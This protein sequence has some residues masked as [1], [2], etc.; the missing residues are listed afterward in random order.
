LKILIV[1]DHRK[2]NDI[3]TK[4]ARGEG[5]HVVQAYD[6]GEA[7]EEL[8]KQAFNIVITD[9]MLPS[10]QGEDLIR[11]I[12]KQSDIYILVISAKTDL[13][14]KIDVLKLGADDYLTK[15]FSV[16]EVMV[17]L[18]NLKK[19]LKVDNSLVISFY[20]DELVI[21]TLERK[22]L[23]KNKELTLTKYEYD[24]LLFLIKNPNQ[25][26]SRDQIISALNS[27]SEA[28]DRVI[29][30]YIK[31]IRRKLEDKAKTP[32]YIKTYYG[33]GYEFIGEQS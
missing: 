26:L 23:F 11:Q 30:V 14:E 13:G 18:A 17:K 25:V 3:L 16:Q 31:N 24:V 6:G 4:L 7:L 27:D 20:Q 10:I 8:S 33:L 22:V 32:R 9:L 19:R 21:K 1:E 5:Y 29:D 15:P 28:Y 12:R 2:I